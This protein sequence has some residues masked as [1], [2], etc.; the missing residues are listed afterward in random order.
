MFDPNKDLLMLV[1]AVYL[2]T[3]ESVRVD[4]NNGGSVTIH[5]PGGDTETF[6]NPNEALTYFHNLYFLLNKGMTC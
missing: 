5:Y 2:T 3:G 1:D 6:R 4:A